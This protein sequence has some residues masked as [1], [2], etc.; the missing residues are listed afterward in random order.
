MS[1]RLKVGLE[2]P[3]VSIAHNIHRA[4]Y[5]S[6]YRVTKAILEPVVAAISDVLRESVSEALKDGIRDAVTST[7][8]IGDLIFGRR[9][10]R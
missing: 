1:D 8:F 6:T 5:D 7:D 10:R 2:A 9:R 3:I 4:Y